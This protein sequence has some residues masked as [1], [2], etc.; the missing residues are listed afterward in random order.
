M[1]LPLYV[2]HTRCVVCVY[3]L[4]GCPDSSVTIVPRLFR[5]LS[6]SKRPPLGWGAPSLLFSWYRSRGVKLTA[7]TELYLY[8]PYTPSRHAP[9]QPCHFYGLFNDD[10]SK[11]EQQGYRRLCAGNDVEGKRP[12]P[13]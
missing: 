6:G 5:F 4:V 12:Q 13:T 11:S 7:R 8:A 9:A 3:D 1:V 10:V 2:F